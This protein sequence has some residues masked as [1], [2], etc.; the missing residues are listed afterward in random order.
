VQPYQ[1]PPQAQPRS[2]AQYE[3]PSVQYPQELPP[4]EQ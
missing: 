4:M 2:D 1:N 3:E